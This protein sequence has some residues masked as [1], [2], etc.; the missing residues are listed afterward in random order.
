MDFFFESTNPLDLGKPA[1]KFERNM[2][3]IRILKACTAEDR[4]A[5]AAEQAALAQYIGWGDAA[6]LNKL[7]ADPSALTDAEFTAAK[8]SA[9]NA[10]YTALPVIAA[11]WEAIAHL[12]I[13]SPQA[14]LLDPSA[15]IGHFKSCAP[16]SLRDAEWVE[17]ELDTITAGILALLHPGSHVYAQGYEETYLPESWFDVVISNVPFGDFGIGN[18]TQKLPRFLRASI[19]DFFFANSVALLR[20][21]GIMAF[22]TSRYTLDK[23]E[24]QM[25]RWLAERMQ[26]LAAV[27]LSCTAF[28]ANAGTEVITDILFLQKREQPGGDNP[29]WLESKTRTLKGMYGYGSYQANVNRYYHERP[30]MILGNEVATGRM[31]RGDSYNVESPNA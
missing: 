23:K 2:D 16:E 11:M 9:L 13:A 19:H 31:Y 22:I 12:G 26:L 24:S 25:R 30:E 28:K 14:R 17:I 20:P 18:S 15:G 27:R 6:L 5:A 7:S 8:A 29:V 10:H 3:A 4:P 21:G 1:Q